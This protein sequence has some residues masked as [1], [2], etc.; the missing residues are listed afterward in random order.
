MMEQVG[1]SP[2]HEYSPKFSSEF[3]GH[4]VVENGISS[5]VYIDHHAT[6]E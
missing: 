5:A 4:G 1:S 3:D 2:A 6:G